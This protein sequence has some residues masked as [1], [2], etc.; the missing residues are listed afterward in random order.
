M[1]TS[2]RPTPTDATAAVP[3]QPLARLRPLPPQAASAPEVPLD[4]PG[5]HRPHRIYVA[6]T[7]HCNRACPWCSTHSGPAGSTFVDVPALLAS[8]PE[9]RPF[10]LQLEGGEPLVHPAFWALVEA[11][12][13]R[14]GCQRLILA[15]NGVCIPRQARRLE[16]FLH[17]L[18]S[19]TTLKL[20]YN[21]HLRD[22]DPGLLTLASALAA[23]MEARGDTFV[24]N[25]RLR[26]G[27]DHDDVA[28]RAAVDDAG[29]AAVANV[30]WLE[31]YGLASDR[32]SWDVPLPVWG[33]FTL[34]N[35]DGSRHGTDLLARS[36]AMGRLP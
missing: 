34:V 22:H 21:H 18:G 15:T 16:A 14:P 36:A 28:V 7:N 12:R 8:L 2:P 9:D 4:H 3:L 26:R 29:L 13:A 30:F 6:L 23:A 5:A 24:L 19:P 20:S 35:P 31:R 1:S 11:A 33:D 25:V 27:E 10:E 17:R 32:E